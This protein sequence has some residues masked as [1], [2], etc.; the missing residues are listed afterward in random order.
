[1]FKNALIF[2]FIG[3]KRNVVGLIGMALA[4]AL[5]ALLFWAFM[6]LGIILPFVLTVAVCGYIGIYAAYPKIKE[7]MID[8]YYDEYGNPKEEKEEEKTEVLSE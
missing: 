1:M 3:L 8:P 6:P 7:V 4:V 5:N 2:T